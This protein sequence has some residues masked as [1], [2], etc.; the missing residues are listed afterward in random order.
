MAIANMLTDIAL[1]LLP[2]PVVWRMS[3]SRAKKIQ[4]SLIF[5]VGIFVVAVTIA[6]VPLV[7]NDG[8]SQT[9]RSMVGSLGL[10]CLLEICSP[11]S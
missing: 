2:I 3:L 11:P 10:L 9:V 6:R 8:V 5:G 1:I 4:L 7:L